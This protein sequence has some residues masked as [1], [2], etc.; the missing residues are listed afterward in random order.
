MQLL[1]GMLQLDPA[2]RLTAIE[3][4]ASEWFDNIREDAVD[5]LIKAD[6]QLKESQ[7]MQNGLR[8]KRS[9]Q[10]KSRA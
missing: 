5:Q 8:D 4:L 10:S 3:A 9:E 7:Q 1:K 2:R 6:R